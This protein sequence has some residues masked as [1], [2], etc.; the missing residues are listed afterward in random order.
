MQATRTGL[1][2]HFTR[3]LI[4]VSLLFSFARI[5]ALYK[6]YHAPMSVYHHFQNYELP[7]LALVANPALAPA[8]DPALPAGEF[9][10]A[11]D[12]DRALPLDDLV[13]LHLRLCVGKEWHRFPSSWLV[14]DEVETRWIRSAFD[15]ILPK[16][17]EEPGP[18]KGLFGRATATVPEG[19]NMFNREEKDRYVRHIRRFCSLAGSSRLTRAH[20]TG[21]RLDVRLPRRPRL[22]LAA[23]VVRLRSRAALRRR[24]VVVG[25]RLLRALPRR[26]KLAAPQ[27]R[28]QPPAAR[29]GGRE[30]VG[31][32]LLAQAQGPIRGD[33]QQGVRG[34]CLVARKKAR[35]EK[36][37]VT[38][39][40]ASALHRSTSFSF[41]KGIG[42]SESEVR[43]E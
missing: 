36:G 33:A 40:L 7:R 13:P 30:R 12:K 26:A 19:M 15:G 28:A 25:P 43:K 17:W 20:T 11:L 34:C 3:F 6:Y 39:S 41:Y 24:R 5:T 10:E 32:V 38:N 8:L 27:P 16:V 1:F 35:G 18:G 9:K 2:S 42:T 21:R 37:V 23:S 4:V 22:P 14:P 31:R 29:V